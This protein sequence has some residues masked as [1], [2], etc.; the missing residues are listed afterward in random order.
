MS[1]DRFQLRRALAFLPAALHPK[2]PNFTVES[3]R[4]LPIV[5]LPVVEFGKQKKKLPGLVSGPGSFF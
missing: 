3:G 4:Q 2:K 1:L 5:D